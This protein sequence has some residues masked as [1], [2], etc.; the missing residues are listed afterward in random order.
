MG[1]RNFGLCAVASLLLAIC[2][3][4]SNAQP[5]TSG[6]LPHF[7][8]VSLRSFDPT[9]TQIDNPSYP[10]SITLKHAVAGSPTHYR[11]SRFSDFRDATWLLYA[12]A[13]VAQVPASW[14]EPFSP[15]RG[16][17]RKV[18]LYFQ[19]RGKNPNAGR[20][21]SNVTNPLTREKTLKVAPEFLNSK[22]L[23]ETITV[24]IWG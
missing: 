16:L 11:V 4:A 22:T 20:P 6:V 18:V 12:P 21:V 1:F 3:V 7:T 15:P 5:L 14:F 10:V 2:P 13:P 23:S 17:D 8:V 9:P 19:L 24:R